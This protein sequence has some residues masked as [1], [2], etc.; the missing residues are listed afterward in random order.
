[1]RREYLDG[2]LVLLEGDITKVAADAIA[3]A[4]NS[5]LV[6]GGGVDGAIHRAGGPSIMKELDSIRAEAG[7]C[8]TGG[9]VVTAAGDLP[10]KW[11]IHTVGPIYKDGRSNEPE[12]L[13]SCYRTCLQL[14]R[15]RGA[16]TITFPSISTGVYGYPISSA[17]AIAL[18]TVAEGL[19]EI[20]QA[21]FVLF[22]VAA[23]ET[24]ADVV[25][26]QL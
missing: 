24:F 9:A 17:A 11:V 10:A 5:Q 14:A 13:A 20:D 22:G 15:E 19:D 7:G 23:F 8:P 25:D 18:R 26:I 21:T 2:R 1:M 3:N 12:L 6:G 4:A 16:R